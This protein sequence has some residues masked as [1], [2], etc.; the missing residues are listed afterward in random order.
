MASLSAI[1][2]Y[3]VKAPT[4]IDQFHRYLIVRDKQANGGAP[5]L[6]D[7]L[8][9]V[10]V[11]APLN[12]SY[13]HRFV[14]LYDELVHL[15]ASAEP[16]SQVPVKRQFIVD[17]LV[18]HNSGTAGTVT[19]IITNSLYFIFIGSVAPGTEDG[20]VTGSFRLRY[21]DE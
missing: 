17:S 15:N 16:G 11:L 4:G 6:T 8:T 20:S 2:Q 9:T 3:S 5:A 19:D 21:R 13:Q 14:I 1:L 10:S 18:Q 12:V 7:V